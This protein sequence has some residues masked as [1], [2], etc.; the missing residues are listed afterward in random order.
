V[1]GV[2]MFGERVGFLK[3]KADIF[4]EKTKAKV[5]ESQGVLSQTI[6]F[7]HSWTRT[8]IGTDIYLVACEYLI[9]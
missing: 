3:F 4:D 5:R 2:D 6:P 9:D 1:Q 7:H 8:I